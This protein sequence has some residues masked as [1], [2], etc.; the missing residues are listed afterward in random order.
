MNN[1][2]EENK[3]DEDRELTEEE[4]QNAAIFR[5]ARENHHYCEDSNLEEVIRRVKLFK[6]LQIKEETRLS[7]ASSGGGKVC[8]NKKLVQTLRSIGK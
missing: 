5:W 1:N 2:E 6:P 8:R 4:A 7:M 3:A